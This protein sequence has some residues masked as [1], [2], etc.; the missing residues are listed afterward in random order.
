[1]NPENAATGDIYEDTSGF[2]TCDLY[3]AAFFQS[4]GIK[5][6]KATRDQKTKRVYFL[7]EK[8]EIMQGLRVNYFSREAKIDAL[9]YADNIKSLKSL[10]HNITAGS[11]VPR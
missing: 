2:S 11:M 3:L 6:L 9:T 1:M 10:C 5:M 4:A 7:F 8:N